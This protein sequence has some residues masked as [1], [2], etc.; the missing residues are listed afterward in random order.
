M[1]R[2][3]P[4]VDDLT[5]SLMG[6]V[7]PLS[8]PVENATPHKLLDPFGRVANAETSGDLKNGEFKFA[9]DH[10]RHRRQLLAARTQSLQAPCD[11]LPDPL[12]QGQTGRRLGHGPFVERPHGFDDDERIPRARHPQAFAQACGLRRTYIG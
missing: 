3:E 8:N 7:E 2:E 11:H 9:A 1:K 10:G 6:E 5:D 4:A 12:G